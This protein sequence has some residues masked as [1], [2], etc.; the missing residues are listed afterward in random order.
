MEPNSQDDILRLRK[1]VLDLIG[2]GYM[3]PESAGTYEQ[4]L[5]QFCQEMERR[6]Q[7]CFQK[8]ASLRL[9]AS[10]AE[11]QGHAHSATASILYSVVNGFYEA[12]MKRL[13]MEAEQEAQRK[14]Q[15]AEAAIEK[16]ALE[17][18]E[19]AAEE[20]RKHAR[21]SHPRRRGRKA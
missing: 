15:E 16:A 8:A 4:T 19:R 7:D 2:L 17:E 11:A 20:A 1:R 14:A 6:K 3:T 12:G 10:A 9:Q 13:Q 21:E 5:L 18:A